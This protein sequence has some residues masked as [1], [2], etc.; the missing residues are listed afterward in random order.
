MFTTPPTAKRIYGHVGFRVHSHTASAEEFISFCQ[1]A[2]LCH[3]KQHNF[4]CVPAQLGI[5]QRRILVQGS[6]QDGT[7]SSAVPGLFL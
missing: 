3:D 2:A 5:D 7:W 6:N 1:D 4:S